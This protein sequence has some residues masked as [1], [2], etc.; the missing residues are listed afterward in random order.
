MKKVQYVV[1]KLQFYQAFKNDMEQN[2]TFI[3]AIPLF[4][5]RKKA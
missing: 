3:M 1:G 2:L 5:E 4:S